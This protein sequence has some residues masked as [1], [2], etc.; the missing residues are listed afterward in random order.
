MLQKS[1]A[2]I[3]VRAVHLLCSNDGFALTLA[4]ATLISNMTPVRDL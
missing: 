3:R 2:E 1:K 4:K